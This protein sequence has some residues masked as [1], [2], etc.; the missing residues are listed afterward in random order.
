MLAYS[1]WSQSSY[2][3][4]K[5]LESDDRKAVQDAL[6]LVEHA[7]RKL[8]DANRTFKQRKPAR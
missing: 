2:D 5:A 4:I 7:V 6:E 8:D 1:L 3:L